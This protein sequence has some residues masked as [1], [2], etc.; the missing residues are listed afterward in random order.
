MS[1]PDDWRVWIQKAA[2]DLLN[3]DN[4]LVSESVPWDTVCFHAQQ[5]AEKHLQA[6][7]WPTARLFRA[8]TTCRLSWDV[9]PPPVML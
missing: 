8:L 4:N 9:V 5:A 1:D 3:V 6:R 7:W 2:N